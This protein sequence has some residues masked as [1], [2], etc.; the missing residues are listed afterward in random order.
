MPP[1]AQCDILVI[2]DD[3]LLRMLVVEVLRNSGFEVCEASNG[4]T[5]LGMLRQT[6]PRLLVADVDLG[7]GPDGLAVG[8]EAQ[9]ILPDLMVVYST[10]R[11]SSMEGYQLGARERSLPKPYEPSKLTALIHRLIDW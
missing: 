7:P 1:L 9:R 8:A 3:P 5:A 11:P 4:D 2:E 10:G 6:E